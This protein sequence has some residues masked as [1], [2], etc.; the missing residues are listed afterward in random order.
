MVVPLRPQAD[1][2]LRGPDLAAS[3]HGQATGAS[4]QEPDASPAFHT[5]L[6]SGILEDPEAAAGLQARSSALAKARITRAL[7]PASQAQ[8][9]EQ[10]RPRSSGSP[11]HIT[12]QQSCACRSMHNIQV[13]SASGKHSCRQTGRISCMRAAQRCHAA[14]R[15]LSLHA[16]PSRRTGYSLHKHIC[17]CHD[18]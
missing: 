17:R 12:A 2:G 10:V 5:D 8:A 3:S 9:E 1:E 15:S 4:D 16:K 6:I 13:V 18:C 11:R 14:G 7:S